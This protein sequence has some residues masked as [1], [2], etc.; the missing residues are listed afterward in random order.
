MPK[1]NIDIVVIGAGAAGM[2]AAATASQRGRGVVLIDHAP[3]LAEKIRISGGGRCNFTNIRAHAECYLSHNPHFCKSALAQYTAADFLNLVQR[4]AIPWHEKK[5]GQLFCD[6][7][8]QDIIDALKAECD[9]GNTAW[10]L[11][12]KILA[13]EQAKNGFIV[14]TSREHWYC[15]SLIV[16]S[17]GLSIPAIGATGF[18]YDLARQ[19]GLSVTP[20][21]AGLVPLTF[22]PRDLYTELAGVALDCHA[23]ANTGPSFRENILFTHRGVSGPAILQISSYWKPGEEIFLDL[24]PEHDA[25][26]LFEETQRTDT[27]LS[28]VLADYLPKR[29]AQI[30]CA[31]L[32]DIKPMKQ[33]SKAELALL[34]TRL[35]NWRVLPSGSQGYKKAEVTCGGIDTANLSSKTMAARRVP[36]LFFVGE[37]VDV[38]GWL[39]GYNFQW[40]WSSGWVA[41]QSA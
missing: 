33:Y 4:H 21:S 18:G 10:R 17:G 6:N 24:L 39:G 34:A 8:S 1:Q 28:N 19:F 32:L 15:Q 7:S 5:L 9:A 25:A 13:I 29:F 41:G 22:E 14:R 40:A 30:F 27:L 38:T 16:A 12:T 3:H 20:L 23:R 31:T 11:G 36:G 26:Q 37:V 35:H 2:M